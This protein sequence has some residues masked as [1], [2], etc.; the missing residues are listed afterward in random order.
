M[1][2][3]LPVWIELLFIATTVLT[4]WLY[5]ISNENSGKFI[6]FVLVVSI[7]H[8]IAAYQG[9]YL[10]FETTPPRFMLILIPSTLVLLYGLL[11]GVRK[12]V[13]KNRDLQLS[14]FMH[15]I[16]VPVEIVLLYLFLNGAVPE[17]MT[18]EG[19]NFDILSGIT[20][21]IVGA[22][23]VRGQLSS[24]L[25]LTWNVVCLFLVL[26]ILTNGVLSAP[27]PFQQFAFDQ[28]NVGVAHF[29][30]VLLPAIIVPTV[31]YTHIIDIFLLRKRLKSEK[32]D[33]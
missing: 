33:S 20:A 22:L 4:V 10:D 23:Y 14:P 8:S 11:P 5:W 13:M 25:M 16:R 26:F 15:I 17:L 2:E 31:I 7:I 18:F 32:N 30:F 6:L 1:I 27:L 19:R 9:F 12:K 29:P 3:N 24:K 21:P 28:P